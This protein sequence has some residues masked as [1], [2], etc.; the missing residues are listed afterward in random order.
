LLWTLV[1]NCTVKVG[2]DYQCNREKGYNGCFIPGKLLLRDEEEGA[3]LLDEEEAGTRQG[4]TAINERTSEGGD[5]GGDDDA[6]DHDVG[7]NCKPKGLTACAYPVGEWPSKKLV[8][9][10]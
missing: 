9:L 8:C 1:Y 7:N 5:T 3:K 10:V 4:T 2:P 6:T